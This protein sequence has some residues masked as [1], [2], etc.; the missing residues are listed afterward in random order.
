MKKS[1]AKRDFLN[2]ILEKEL[3]K[4]TKKIIDIENKGKYHKFFKKVMEE[5]YEENRNKFEIIFRKN[6]F[7]LTDLKHGSKSVVE[8]NPD[9]IIKFRTGEKS[10]EY[11]IFEFLDKQLDIKT[12][13]DI[14][15]CVIIDNCRILLL[16][17]KTARKHKEATRIRNVFIDGLNKSKEEDSSKNKSP[18][19]SVFTLHI[20]IYTTKKKIKEE[21]MDEIKK[22]IKL[23]KR[24]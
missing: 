10:Y 7:K 15:R 19:L 11:I 3:E 16:I 14:S 21:I 2:D 20:P 4:I 24:I 1:N 6:P 22:E 12:M 13:A 8:Y 5:F 9:F 18:F 17:S 23:P